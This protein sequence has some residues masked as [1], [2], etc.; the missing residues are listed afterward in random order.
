MGRE[1]GHETGERQLREEAPAVP[2]RLC[3]GSEDA[4]LSFPHWAGLTDGSDSCGLLSLPLLSRP[5][6]DIRVLS[7]IVPR[8]PWAR[9]SHPFAT[10]PLRL[11]S[12]SLH[13]VGVFDVPFRYATLERGCGRGFKMVPPPLHVPARNVLGCALDGS[14]RRKSSPRSPPSFLHHGRLASNAT[15]ERS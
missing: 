13:T 15:F 4:T 2:G 14:L 6:V 1:K 7:Y 9:S 8:H 11:P 10:P 3:L 5:P 12:S